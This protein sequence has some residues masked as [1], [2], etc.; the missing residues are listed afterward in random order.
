[1]PSCQ[2]LTARPAREFSKGVREESIGKRRTEAAPEEDFGHD[3]DL[4]GGENVGRIGITAARGAGDGA[5][6]G[7]FRS[8]DC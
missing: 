8:D 5:S 7:V 4:C 6:S 1:M 3:C 2:N